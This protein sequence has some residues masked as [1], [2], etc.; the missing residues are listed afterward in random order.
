[1]KLAA[2]RIETNN[3]INVVEV[4]AKKSESINNNV[5]VVEEFRNN[6]NIVTELSEERKRLYKT[7]MSNLKPFMTDENGKVV[8]ATGNIPLSLCF[9]DVRYQGLRRHS[10]LKKL[11]DK[12]DINKLSPII[13]VPHPE[14][15]RFAIVDGQGR[16]IVAPMKGLD[17]LN[18]IILMVYPED[19]KERLLFEAEYFMTQNDETEP[20]KPIEKHLARVLRG[21]KT[22]TELNDMLNKYGINF[23]DNAGQRTDSVLGSYTDT[24]AIAKRN[25]ADG[26]DFIFSIIENAGWKE[27]TNGY[28]TSIMRS[29][30]YMYEAHPDYREAIHRFLSRELRQMDPSL[31]HAS[32]RAAYPKREFRTSCIL[33]VED[34]VCDNLN[35][36][37]KIY[38][39]GEK[40]GIQIVK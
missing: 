3:S 27:E 32:G 25:G 20:V 10:K 14:E 16:S 24:Y 26:L 37:K 18:A 23:V 15:Y 34:M 17:S 35:I 5:K 40:R 22:A 19:T 1:M 38:T 11:I 30:G 2:K 9:V 39:N 36:D 29:L 28:S 12:W 31:F 4:S 7:I 8:Q 6:T 21:D 33:Y 13:L